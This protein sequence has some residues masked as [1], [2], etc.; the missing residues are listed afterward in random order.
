MHCNADGTHTGAAALPSE[1]GSLPA[2]HPV[3]VA[4]TQIRTVTSSSERSDASVARS[5]KT[6]TAQSC[7][8]TSP[9]PRNNEAGPR[10]D[11]GTAVPGTR[12]A[13]G[14]IPIRGFKKG[15]FP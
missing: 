12:D 9:H 3:L 8:P 11:A 6:K 7:P 2:P 4:P 1:G 13:H 15:R 5:A 14:A 10:P